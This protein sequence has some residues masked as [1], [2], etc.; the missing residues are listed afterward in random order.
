ML[1]ENS[2]ALWLTNTWWSETIDP[3]TNNYFLIDISHVS[4]CGIML[5]YAALV[6]FIIPY[7]MRNREPF[8]IKKWIIIYDFTLVAINFYFF[9]KTLQ[10]CDWGRELLKWSDTRDDW[11][12]RAFRYIDIAHLYYLSKL[13]DMID[14]FFMA[15]RKRYS[16]ISF[17]H[18]WHHVS[19]SYAGWL[20]CR[21][22]PCKYSYH[23][24]NICFI[25][26][27]DFTI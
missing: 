13:V 6:W 23:E 15:F 26:C 17:L 16:Q 2:T 3:R 19:L 27:F 8:N 5:V 4:I 20:Y 21:Y 7:L 24:T 1:G 9:I 12:E 10:L 11:S 25:Y 14:T 22:N 18:V